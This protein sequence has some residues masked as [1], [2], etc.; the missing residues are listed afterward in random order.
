MMCAVAS[1]AAPVRFRPMGLGELLDESFKLYRRHFGIMAGLSLLIAIPNLV[2][3]I[4]AGPVLSNPITAL[5][6]ATQNNPNPELTTIREPLTQLASFLLIYG[7]VSLLLS[8]ITTGTLYRA[9]TTLALGREETIQSAL[10]ATL[11]RYFGVLGQTLI[12]YLV[13][14]SMGLVI[15]IPVAIWVLGRWITRLPALFAEQLGPVNALGR[16]WALVRDNWWRSVG[17]FVVLIILQW[18]A[19][20]AIGTAL[21]VLAVVIPGGEVLRSSVTNALSTLGGA[22]VQPIVAIGITLLYF[23]LRV[24]KEGFDLEQLARQA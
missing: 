24:R 16:S 13:A 19:G 5:Q 23:D 3:G 11:R 2:F 6:Q 9:S 22:F 10:I 12:F 1:A 4:L 18:I 21:G 7:L 14:A 15:T 8:P 20:L 17:V